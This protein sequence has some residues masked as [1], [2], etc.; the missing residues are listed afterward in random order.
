MSKSTKSAPA[1]AEVV[2]VEAPIDPFA[3]VPVTKLADG[4]EF[5]DFTD[6]EGNNPFK[7][8]A[9]HSAARAVRSPMKVNY[10]HA[11]A[12]LIPGTNRKELRPGS[13]YGDIQAIVNAAGRA[14]IATVQVI[15]M[16]RQGQI[17]NKRSKY[18]GAL[19][20]IGWAEG[21]LDTAITK[22]IVGV[23]ATK[24]APSLTDE[25]VAEANEAGEQRKLAANG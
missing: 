5:R 7:Y 11:R 9:V 4:V 8:E 20:P 23:H 24:Q 22:N 19:P 16:L 6:V 21:W 3:N 2:A 25:V 12:L 10:K 15:A 13:V 18:C 14:G 17:G 1:A